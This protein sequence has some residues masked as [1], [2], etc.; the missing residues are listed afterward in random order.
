MSPQ[1]HLM[2]ALKAALRSEARYCELS[3]AELGVILELK[4]AA[5]G[6][7]RIRIAA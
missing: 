6:L 7:G 3:L 2:P 4:L 1:K 5:C